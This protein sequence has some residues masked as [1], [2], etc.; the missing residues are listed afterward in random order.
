VAFVPEPPSSGISSTEEDFDAHPLAFIGSL[1]SSWFEVSLVDG[2][3]RLDHS[4]PDEVGFPKLV[5]G[6]PNTDW[7]GETLAVLSDDPNGLIDAPNG[8]VGLS[9]TSGKDGGPLLKGEKSSLLPNGFE[10]GTKDDELCLD[11]EPKADEV[12]FCSV[13]D[14]NGDEACLGVDPNGKLGDLGTDPKG[15]KLFL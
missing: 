10:P 7:S 5:D 2:A 8:E 14:P 12:V 4:C 9:S 15:E 11:V 6:L 13:A 1:V 3:P